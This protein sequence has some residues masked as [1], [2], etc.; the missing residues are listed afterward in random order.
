MTYSEME[1]DID[2]NDMFCIFLQSYSQSIKI[3]FD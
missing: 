2:E 3:S 1:F